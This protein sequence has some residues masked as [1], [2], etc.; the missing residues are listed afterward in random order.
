M[1]P[2]AEAAL[3]LTLQTQLKA[4]ASY[5]QTTSN[6]NT[7]LILSAGFEVR[8]APEPVGELPVPTN[9][10]LDPE[11]HPGRGSFVVEKCARIPWV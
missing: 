3:R 10:E 4:R 9:L 11:R 5:V 7:N 6:G 1:P 8:R 2:V